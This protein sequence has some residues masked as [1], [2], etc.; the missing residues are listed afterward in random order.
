MA[1]GAGHSRPRPSAGMPVVT[2]EVEHTHKGAALRGLLAL[3]DR[4]AGRRPAVIVF[5][6][7]AGRGEFECQK[8]RS[9]AEMG[10]AGFA[11]D[12]YGGARTGNSRDENAKLMK[13]FVSDRA[14][15]AARLVAVLDAVKGLPEV[16]PGRVAA[17]GFCFGGL[18]ALDLARSG[19]DLRGVTSFHGLLG[20]PPAPAARTQK[21]RAKVLVLHGNDDPMAPPKDVAALE[22]ELTQAGADWQVVVYGGTMH[23]FTNRQANDPGFGTVYNAAA[24]CRSWQALVSFLGEALV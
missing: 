14:F 2:R 24:D 10:F 15:L 8:A 22:Q 16:D 17:I 4:R 21:I 1:P 18:C 19:A 9:I 11:A 13:P 20:P 23:A 7:W 6:A 3:D 12:L 5:H